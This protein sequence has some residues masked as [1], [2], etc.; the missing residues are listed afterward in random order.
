MA[1]SLIDTL[2]E[3]LESEDTEY[4]K[5]LELSSD[6]TSYIVRGDLE[7][8]ER[9]TEAEQPVVNR[10]AVLERR[11]NTTMSEIAKILNTDVEGL[12]LSVLV[13][14]LGKSPNE[15]RKLAAIHDKLGITLREMKML[16]ERNEE[17]LNSAIEMVDFNLSMIQAMRK[18]PE[19]A[20]YNKGAYNVGSAI[21]SW[22]PTGSFDAKQ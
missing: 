6:K 19:T 9:I 20:N 4:H 10:I 1:A 16:N 15:Q 18:A 5:L 17:L 13:S 11:R 7:G 22:S 3:T 12:K 21:G 8:L 2:I 14:L